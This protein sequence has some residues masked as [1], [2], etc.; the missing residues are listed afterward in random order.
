MKT[1]VLIPSTLLNR[2]FSKVCLY[3][4]YILGACF[5]TSFKIHPHLG[6]HLPHALPGIENVR[7]RR[8][9]KTSDMPTH[10]YLSV[11]KIRR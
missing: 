5:L 2:G 11:S 3:K 9:N 6:V 8:R 4:A 10:F 7:P 1:C